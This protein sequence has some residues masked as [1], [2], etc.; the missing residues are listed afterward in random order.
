MP[1][2]VGGADLR[3]SSGRA[4]GILVEGIRRKEAAFVSAIASGVSGEVE[5]KATAIAS[6]Y[7]AVL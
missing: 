3:C 2:R 5:S 4:A 7:E 6:S 1:R